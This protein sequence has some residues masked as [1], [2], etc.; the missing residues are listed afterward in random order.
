MADNSR[1]THLAVKLD[2]A[3]RQRAGDAIQ[4]TGRALPCAVSQASGQ[5][6]TVS[7]QVNGSPYTLPSVTM[8]LQSSLYDW[9][10]VQPNDLG[11]AVPADTYLGGISGLGGGT[12]DLSQRANL[13]THFFLPVANKSWQPP[14]GDPNKRVIQGPSGARV[15]DVAGKTVIVVDGSNITITVAAG[16][17]VTISSGGTTQPVKLADGSNSLVLMAE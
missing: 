2:N 11:V 5:I 1:K 9:I 15:Q 13:A 16:Q 8:P 7:W 12:A 10:P 3:A 6:V 14:G 17:R 4:L